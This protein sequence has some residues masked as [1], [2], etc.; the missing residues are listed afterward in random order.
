M[1]GV[2]I[3]VKPKLLFIIDV[4]IIFFVYSDYLSYSIMKMVL[5]NVASI[6]SVITK[7]QTS[8]LVTT[9]IFLLT[10]RSGLV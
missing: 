2:S 6:S 1:M 5:S 7:M 10:Q 4:V 8:I 3:Q 9:A